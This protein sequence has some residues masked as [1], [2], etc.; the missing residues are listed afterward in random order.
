MTVSLRK[1]FVILK[2][3]S[4]SLVTRRIG[5]EFPTALKTGNQEVLTDVNSR[6]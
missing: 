1:A 4:D 3:S 6:P 5:Q 2:S